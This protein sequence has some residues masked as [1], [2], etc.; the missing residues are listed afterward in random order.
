MTQSGNFNYNYPLIFKN[1]DYEIPNADTQK[2]ILPKYLRLC[3]YEYELNMRH[4]MCAT[5]NNVDIK[6]AGLYFPK[7]ICP[8]AFYADM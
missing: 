5:E 3:K 4:F 2:L 8:F 6:Y 7:L 1:T